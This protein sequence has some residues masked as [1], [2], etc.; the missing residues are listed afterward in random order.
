VTRLLLCDD[1]QHYR[2]ALRDALSA[3]PAI[4]LVGEA[5][6]GDEAVR[7]AREQRPDVV[8]MDMG[9]P[10]LNGI[11]ATRRIVEEQPRVR[12]IGLTAYAQPSLV[13]PMIESGIRGLC[14][15]G[16]PL[17]ELRRAI[18]VSES[19]AYLDERAIGS[20]LREVANLYRNQ[21]ASAT[22]LTAAASELEKALLAQRQLGRGVVAALAAAVEAR[23]GY[24]ASH[25]V[26]VANAALLLTARIAPALADD[27]DLEYGYLL[28]DVGKLGVPDAVLNKTGPLSRQERAV[29]DGHV[30]LGLDMLAHLPQLDTAREIIAYHHERWDGHGYPAALAGEMIPLPARIFSVCDA[31]DAMTSNRPYRSALTPA[32]ARAELHEHAGDQFDPSVVTQFLQLLESIELADTDSPRDQ[33][34][35]EPSESQ[36][37]DLRTAL[38]Q[39]HDRSRQRWQPT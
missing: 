36:P 37:L 4:E 26:R 25:A 20:T 34:Q 10:G 29:M 21:Q 9:L 32:L 2:A 1:S 19:A 38:D 17:R 23:D 15:K 22:A 27:P 13:I 31:Y 8:L 16:G 24:T 30:Q 33:G 12:V 6:D 39:L 7:L 5:T 18:R 14:L 28:H 35:P 11:E 3:D